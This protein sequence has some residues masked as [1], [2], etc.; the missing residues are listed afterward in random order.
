MTFFINEPSCV[1]IPKIEKSIHLFLASLSKTNQSI[2]VEFSSS[3]H[4]IIFTKCLTSFASLHFFFTLF[5]DVTDRKKKM[6][7]YFES[8]LWYIL[9]QVVFGI[10]V[11]LKN[12][13]YNG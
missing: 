13:L 8:E 9:Q 5:D 1:D 12:E 4:N 7:I 10:H 3:I 6:N 2:V 11:L